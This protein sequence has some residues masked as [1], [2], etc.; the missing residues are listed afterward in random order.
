MSALTD[1]AERKV[2]DAICG[3]A[4]FTH[5]AAMYLAL[6]TADFGESGTA[7]SELSGNGYARTQITFG[8]AAATDGST[9]VTTISNTAAIDFPAA[10]GTQGS[11][12]H[13][14]LMTAATGGDCLAIGSFTTAKT[15]EA[16][17][18]LRVAT[19]DLTLTSS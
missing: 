9:N 4:T 11:I 7:S 1:L 3:K 10:T 19:G 12:S 6:G 2:L 13:W 18:V 15:I 16:N 5:T 17:D 14:K 8:S